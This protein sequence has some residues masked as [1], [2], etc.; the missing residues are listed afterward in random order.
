MV[1]GMADEYAD[2]DD[3][4]LSAIATTKV[5]ASA[6]AISAF[7]EAALPHLTPG[8]V[9]AFRAAR[10]ACA[11]YAPGYG[12]HSIDLGRYMQ[13]IAGSS[14]EASL[15]DRARE[16]EACL[17]AAVLANYASKKRQDKYGSNGLAIYYPVSAAA[18]A[19]D[20]DGAG[21]AADNKTFPVEFVE[22][23][24]WSTFLRQYWKLV[25]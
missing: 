8:N 12:L 20:V 6:G 7:A 14:L 25:P 15:R 16:V 23:E 19:K 1:K 10:A 17:K 11:S 4:T 21:Y 13:Q 22:K 9:A 18:Y 2:L 3:T 5:P 24:R